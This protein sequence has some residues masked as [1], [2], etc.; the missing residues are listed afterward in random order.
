M[1]LSLYS[2]ILYKNVNIDNDDDGDE[3]SMTV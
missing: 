1:A 2:L 3:V